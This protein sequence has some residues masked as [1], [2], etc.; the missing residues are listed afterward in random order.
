MSK[1]PMLA[2]GL[3]P[4]DFDIPCSRFAISFVADPKPWAYFGDQPRR[5]AAVAMIALAAPQPTGTSHPHL[6]PR[7]PTYQKT[8][9]ARSVK[10]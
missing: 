9:G 2:L 1:A 4:S 5:Y 10:A 6:R 3:F 8:D 7:R